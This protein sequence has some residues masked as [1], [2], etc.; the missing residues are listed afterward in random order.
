MDLDFVE[1][2]NEIVCSIFYQ[3]KGSERHFGVTLLNKNESSIKLME[4]GD[5][6]HFTNLE[7]MILQANPENKRN[8]FC[9]IINLPKGLEG[10]KIL[11]I[12][13]LCD[14]EFL[15][16]DP[17]DFSRSD[18]KEDLD[19]IRKEDAKYDA[20][21]NVYERA[22]FALKA[23][24]LHT[25]LVAEAENHKRYVISINHLS[26]YMRLDKAALKA[27]D[28]FSAK[29]SDRDAF[30]IFG[31][32][33][34]CKTHMGTRKLKL[35]LKQPLLKID[36]I[37]TRHNIV[38]VLTDNYELR[39]ETQN[40]LK[41][42]PDLDKLYMAF[43]RVKIR[44]KNKASLSDCVRVYHFLGAL[45]RLVDYLG[46]FKFD[47]GNSTAPLVKFREQVKIITAEIIEP[48]KNCL[49]DF[50]KLAQLI[51]ESIDM[52]EVANN[53]YLINPNF[54]DKLKEIKN[55]LVETKKEILSLRE[56]IQTELATSKEV[57]LVES[58]LHTYVFEVNKKEG[59]A[60]FRRTN[61]NVKQLS[62]KKTDISF[63]VP[64]LTDLCN[65]FRQLQQNYEDTQVGLVEKV[66]DI[67]ATYYPVLE[68]S[69]TIIAT[70]DVLL[71]FAQV[72][73]SA[74]TPFVEP[75]V[76]EDDESLDIQ[77]GR[78]ILIE[79]I[80]E[81]CIANDCTMNKTDSS[82]HIITGPNMGGKSTYIR[83]VGIICLLSQIGC[84]V[85]CSSANLPP[86]DAIIARVG[87]SDHQLR[88]VSTFMQEMI[89]TSCML[90]S[91]TPRSLILVDEL[92][93]GTS[94]NEGFGLAWA[95]AKYIASSV[96]CF[97]LFATHF[98]E[99]TA[100]EN[101]VERVKNFHVSAIT[102]DNKL[103]MLYK[104]KQGPVDRSF[105]LHV[106]TMLEF[107]EEVIRKA[108]FMAENIENFNTNLLGFEK[109]LEESLGSMN[110][111]PNLLQDI[112]NDAKKLK[113]TQEFV[114]KVKGLGKEEAQAEY[115]KF[116]E[117]FFALNQ[118]ASQSQ[119]E[120]QIDG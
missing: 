115:D 39:F 114:A 53:T 47:D 104:V 81:S 63:T 1:E 46:G 70:L 84:F 51:E 45:E 77:E 57:K 12:F 49:T 74:T 50:Q 112:S 71:S 29:E 62:T 110:L 87:A 80:N 60:A 103:T 34:K 78:H 75:T 73:G 113:L 107:P 90:K 8:E 6:E 66:L 61:L 56:E 23:A 93:R 28:V 92:G 91:A 5:N 97:C 120:M 54:D 40:I 116:R 26:D 109:N 55:E 24:L 88:G 16:K 32:L 43:Q 117:E 27:M 95:I 59:D 9:C 22:L 33:N 106:A 67:V 99:L 83:S 2:S 42:I 58:A 31:L 14:V 17:K 7:S 25:N 101:E 48:L 79:T 76:L 18:V 98:H 52:G 118:L 15:E 85:P 21:I 96:K 36:Q 13:K 100:L 64:E 105:G 89:E 108:K 30:T 4:F 72:S 119:S 111:N 65:N 41:K 20:N 3:L 10:E 38:G 94:T 11:N 37:T 69:S 19:I 82:L 44:S 86:V 35:W 68:R 102:I